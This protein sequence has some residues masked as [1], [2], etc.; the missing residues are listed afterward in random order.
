MTAWESKSASCIVSYFVAIADIMGN[1]K[2]RSRYQGITF[3]FTGADHHALFDIYFGSS[4]AGQVERLKLAVN[5][6]TA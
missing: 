6:G 1:A 3:Q 4:A 2:F 5:T